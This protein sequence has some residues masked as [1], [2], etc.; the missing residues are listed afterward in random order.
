ME[1]ILVSEMSNKKNVNDNLV[2]LISKI[3][4]KIT[5]RRCNFLKDEDKCSNFSYVHSSIKKK[6]GQNRCFSKLAKLKIK[7]RIN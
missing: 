7:K 6:Y 1:K 5:I 4:E 3:G 2:S